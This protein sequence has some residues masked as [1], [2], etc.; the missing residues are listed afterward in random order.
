MAMEEMNKAKNMAEN[1]MAKLKQHYDDFLNT[2]HS[3][4]IKYKRLT[5][6][7]THNEEEMTKKLVQQQNKTDV[8]LENHQL[9]IKKLQVELDSKKMTLL[10]HCEQ[11]ALISVKDEY[12]KL[13]DDFEKQCLVWSDAHHKVMGTNMQLENEIRRLKCEIES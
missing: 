2:H 10:A 5:E 1:E 8:L 12:L 9:E 13:K 3:Q 7:A 6:Q 4:L 11:N